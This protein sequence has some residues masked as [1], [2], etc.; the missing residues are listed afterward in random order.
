MR[1]PWI[2]SRYPKYPLIL[3]PLLTCHFLLAGEENAILT[4]SIFCSEK[5]LILRIFSFVIALNVF[6]IYFYDFDI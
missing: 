6:A 2:P 5:V 3:I 4:K 1:L